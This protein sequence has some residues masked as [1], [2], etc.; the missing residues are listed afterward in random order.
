V[1]WVQQAGAHGRLAAQLA[2]DAQ[3]VLG[4][5]AVLGK[6]AAMVGLGRWAALCGL[7]ETCQLEHA[8]STNLMQSECQGLAESATCSGSAWHQERSEKLIYVATCHRTL[9]ER[10]CK[11]ALSLCGKSHVLHMQGV[12]GNVGHGAICCGIG[13]VYFSCHRH[14]TVMADAARKPSMHICQARQ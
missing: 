7:V 1:E 4:T 11:D 6:L 8:G 10:S 3:A 14:G 12:S 13:H 2:L 9:S 5:L